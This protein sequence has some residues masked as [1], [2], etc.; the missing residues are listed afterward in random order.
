MNGK[1]SLTITV[2]IE[3]SEHYT[4]CYRLF[5]N[6]RRYRIAIA[7]DDSRKTNVDGNELHV[8]F[9]IYSPCSDSTGPK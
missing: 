7:H 9:H 1:I 4:T 2:E 3:S 8:S 5:E 6:S